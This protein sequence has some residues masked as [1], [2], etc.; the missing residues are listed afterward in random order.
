MHRLRREADADG[1]DEEAVATFDDGP[2][3]MWDSMS[4][5]RRAYVI[6]M[7]SMILTRLVK[8]SITHCMKLGRLT[9]VGGS[10]ISWRTLSTASAICLCSPSTLAGLAN[11]GAEDI[12]D[13]WVSVMNVK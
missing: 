5:V 4:I 12:V 8:M 11:C 13:D 6:A 1:V 10:S 9:G 3:R 7:S 2:S